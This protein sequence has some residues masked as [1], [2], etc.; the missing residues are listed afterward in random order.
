[1]KKFLKNR[2]ILIIVF[3]ITLL[4]IGYFLSKTLP[5][6]L[7]KI[8]Y[9]PRDFKFRNLNTEEVLIEGQGDFSK[10]KPTE[11]RLENSIKLIK[12]GSV[13]IE[14]KKGEFFESLNRLILLTNQF[15]GNIINSQIFREE[16]KNS[17]YIVIMIPSKDFDNF[18]TK[19]SELG[20]IKSIITTTSDVSM[21]YYDHLGRL[22]ILESQRELLLSFLK[23]AKELKDIL[24]IRSELEKIETEIES[25]KGK[26]NYLD[27][28][29]QFSEI[30][31]NLYEKSEE[32]P[33]WKKSDFIN[34]II[35]S[36]VY[37]LNALLTSILTLIIFLAFVLPWILIGYLIYKILIK[38]FKKKEEKV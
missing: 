13:E 11:S 21:E 30:S 14:V 35:N 12:K 2:T 19:L 22:K 10:I 6:F 9:N 37:S 1:M 25:V 31:I 4:I 18:T 23:E 34:R 8:S 27:Y 7:F 3:L 26:I 38:Y 5:K 15:N 32:L 33:W 36:L 20:Y 17:G 24:T 28:H 16:K 29:S